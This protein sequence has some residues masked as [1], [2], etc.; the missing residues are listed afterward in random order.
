M[1]LKPLPFPKNAL[2][3]YISEETI[4][5]HYGKHHSTYVTNLN[6][7]LKEKKIEETSLKELIT[8]SYGKADLIGIYNNAGQVFNHDEFWQSMSAPSENKK[9]PEI[10]KSKIESSFGSVE[11]LKKEFIQ[12]GV[13]LFGSGWVWL[14]YKND[15]LELI[16][17][18]NADTPFIVDAK[19]VITCDVWEHSY[20]IDYRNQRLQYLE[21]FINHLVNWNYAKSQLEE[22]M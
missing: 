5:Y 9:I 20:Y 17:S 22:I 15:K 4:D 19:P 16:K 21:N 10:V 3:P 14:V 7:L 1:Q 2:S 12:A 11:E 13:T 8:M 18:Q 6:N